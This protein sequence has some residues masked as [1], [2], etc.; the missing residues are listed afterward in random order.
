MKHFIIALLSLFLLTTCDDGNIIVEK[1]K[2]E[3]A[4]LQKCSESN[5]LYKI[6]DAEALILN[7]SENNF[8]NEVK[9]E[10][11][12]IG[13]GTSIVYNRYNSN[14]QSSSICGTP[15]QFILETWSCIGGSIEIKSTAIYDTVIPTKI[16]AYNHAITFKNIVFKAPDKQVVYT[17][18]FYG[19]Y[20]TN[21]IDLAFDFALPTDV[22]TC[23]TSNL[24]FKYNTNK[25]LLFDVDKTALFQ[26]SVTPVGSPRTAL[27]NN[28]TNKVIY[29]EYSGGLNY[30]FFCGSIT[31]ST[32]T[33]SSEWIAENG[34]L[35]TSGIIKVVTEATPNPSIFKHTIYLFNTTFKNGVKSY[36]PNA[37]GD[38]MFGFY[39]TSL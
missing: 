12:S 3:N 29:R 2:F 33:L 8:P 31:P 27:I 39:Y 26:N 1:F 30:D 34:V 23:T 18:Y 38:Y 32:P 11:I 20:R 14:V 37:T 36:N 7:T 19:N 21:V 13:T 4:T 28:T 25:V 6:N 15:S 35:D 16:I 10:T 24:I 5:L 9:T 22:L 17:E